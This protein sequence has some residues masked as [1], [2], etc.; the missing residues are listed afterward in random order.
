MHDATTAWAEAMGLVERPSPAHDR[1]DRARIAW[2]AAHTQPESTAEDLLIGA[3]WHL[4]LFMYDDVLDAGALGRRP[5]AIAH[6]NEGLL[7]ALDQGPTATDLPLERALGDFM[8]HLT[9]RVD[10]RWRARFV[11]H[12]RRYLQAVVWEAS[13]RETDE[14]PDTTTYV[15][16][17]RHTGAVF[18]CLDLVH[19]TSGV[20]ATGPLQEHVYAE[21]LAVMANDHVVWVNDVLGLDKELGERN[22]NNLVLVLQAERGLPLAAATAEAITWCN[23]ELLAYERL[24]AR[25]RTLLPASELEPYLANLEAWMGGH[26]GWYADT[27]RYDPER[28][29]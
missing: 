19:A 2:L 1:L 3:K 21:E 26:I 7:L 5:R 4:W 10:D 18:A 29:R 6:F 27:G 13:N 24:A 17:R 15:K 20:A 8:A 22:M 14:V 23:R 9:R 12:A 28:G 16:L 25:A 11:A